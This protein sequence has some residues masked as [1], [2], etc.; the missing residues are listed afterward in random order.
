VTA[1]PLRD[2]IAADCPHRLPD[3]DRHLASRPVTPAF[4]VLWAIEHRI[5]SQ[6]RLEAR[7]DRLYRRAQKTRS[8]RRAKRILAKTSRIRHDIQ[9]QVT[10]EM[11]L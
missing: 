11:Q 2:R 9:Q 5:S 7:L 1:D 3:Y 10:K 4:R 8:I 6:P